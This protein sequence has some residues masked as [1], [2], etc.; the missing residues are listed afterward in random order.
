MCG[1]KGVKPPVE[2]GERT[3]D[4]S[5]GHAGKEGPHNAGDPGF[6]TGSAITQYFCLGNPRE[7]GAWRATVH[8]VAKS[9]TLSLS[10]F[11]PSVMGL[12]R[13]AYPI[14]PLSHGSSSLSLPYFCNEK[15]R[16]LV[17]PWCPTLCD[18]MDCSPPGSSVHGILQARILEWVAIPF[19]KADSIHIQIS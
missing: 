14:S 3:R 17:T 11:S 12:A 2:I 9:R 6:I 1:L 4:C 15:V 16:V 7:S 13:S 10:Y 18:P 5:P 8:R 19:S